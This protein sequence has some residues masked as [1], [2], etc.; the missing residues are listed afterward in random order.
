MRKQEHIAGASMPI[1]TGDGKDELNLVEFP[2]CA[3]THRLRP[4]QKTLQFEDQV[5]DEQRGTMRTRQ[6]TITGSDAYGLP[7]ALDDEVLVGLIQL[8]KR[9]G[10]AERKVPFTRYQLIQLLGWRD[11]TKSYERLAASLH[12]WTGVTLSYRNAWWNKRRGGW[13]PVKVKHTFAQGDQ[14][15]EREVVMHFHGPGEAIQAGRGGINPLWHGDRNPARRG[16]A[17]L[18]KGVGGGGSEAS[19]AILGL[20]RPIQGEHACGPFSDFADL[21]QPAVEL[22]FDH[23][24]RVGDFGA[25]GDGG[26]GIGGEVVVG[27]TG[28][29]YP[30]RGGEIARDPSYKLA[31][32][33]SGVPPS[34]WSKARNPRSVPGALETRVTV[35]FVLSVGPSVTVLFGVAEKPLPVAILNQIR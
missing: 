23:V 21:P 34:L 13:R 8:S 2:L 20:R 24:G 14:V 12:R 9:Q 11:E 5:W 3:L 35:R 1:I 16:R 28:D 25:D 7:T 10:F 18:A 32:K 30:R 4:D 22:D 17:D 27:R 15:R 31:R 6:L 33:K 19:P 26:P 29:L